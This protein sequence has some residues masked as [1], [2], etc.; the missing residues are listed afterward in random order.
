[1]S[2]EE[3]MKKFISHENNLRNKRIARFT[4]YTYV[5]CEFCFKYVLPYH[6]NKNQIKYFK[7]N[8]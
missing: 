2:T 4:L 7:Q 5:S 6:F 3:G 1:M 8:L